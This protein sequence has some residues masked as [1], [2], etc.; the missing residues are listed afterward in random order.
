LYADDTTL[1]FSQK[2]GELMLTSVETVMD[3][4][5]DYFCNND[6]VFLIRLDWGVHVGEVAA[7]LSR[8]CYALRIVRERAGIKA[9]L[10]A[11]HGCIGSRIRYS[12]IF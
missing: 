11:Y 12:L 8:Y 6:L 2:N 7:S 10:T 1:I 9:A 4:L 5:D 3:R